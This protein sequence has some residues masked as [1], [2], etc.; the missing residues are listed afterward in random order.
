M[1]LN[2]AWSLSESYTSA[3]QEVVGLMTGS[4]LMVFGIQEVK[5]DDHNNPSDFTMYKAF[6]KNLKLLQSSF[7]VTLY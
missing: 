7:S 4:D 1:F 3:H 6:P 5:L 2:L